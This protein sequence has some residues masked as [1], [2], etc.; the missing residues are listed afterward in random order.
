MRSYRV[1]TDGLANKLI[2]HYLGGRRLVLYVQSLLKPL[3]TLNK[4]WKEWADEKR[5]EAAM[6]SQVIMLEYYLNRKYKKYLTDKSKHIIIS[7]GEVNG[8]PMYWESSDS[9]GVDTLTIYQESEGKESSKAFRWK[10]E[11]MAESDCSFLVCVPSID[12]QRISK[13]EL[14]AMISYHVSKYRIAG[15]KFKVIYI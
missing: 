11:K 2:P 14:S 9:T 6:T 3:D 4:T 8:V 13:D 5:I 10:D 1:D 7:D 15:K 12:E